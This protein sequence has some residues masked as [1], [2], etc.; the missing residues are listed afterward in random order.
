MALQKDNAYFA[1]LALVTEAIKSGVIKLR[2]VDSTDYAVDNGTA[3][4][5]YLIALL[6]ELQAELPKN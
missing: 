1:A 4:A 5:K 6:K 3:D 2:G